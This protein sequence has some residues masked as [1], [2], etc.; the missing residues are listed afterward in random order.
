MAVVA[1]I[2]WAFPVNMLLTSGLLIPRSL[3]HSL[4]RSPCCPYLQLCKLLKVTKLLRMGQSI[5]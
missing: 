4:L 1:S 5:W 3:H 2:N